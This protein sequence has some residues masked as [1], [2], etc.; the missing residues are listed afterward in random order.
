VEEIQRALT[1]RVDG[2]IEAHK[3][4]EFVS[5]M[6]TQATLTELTARV[7]GLELAVRELAAE[8]EP[9]PERSS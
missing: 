2:L 8:L 5:T 6:G 1:D 7:V 9:L 3:Q 4:R